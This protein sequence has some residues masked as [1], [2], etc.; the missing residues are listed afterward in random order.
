[1]LSQ[2]FQDWELLIADD[3]SDAPTR[4][5]LQSLLQQPRMRVLWL[6]H[7]GN[8]PAVR[9]QALRAARGEFVAFLDSDDI[10]VPRKL[11]LQI[12]AM[13]AR[14]AH[15]WSY[16]GFAMID[17]DGATLTGEQAKRQP[18]DGQF[19]EQLITGEAM[20]MQ[21]SVV[22]RRDLLQAV[23]GYDEA[24]PVCGDYLLW[25]MLAQR[26]DIALLKT[27]L[28]Q[29]RRHH[30]HYFTDIEALTDMQR[31]CAGLLGTDAV[32]RLEAVLH[33][34]RAEVAAA[35]AIGYAHRKR[36]LAVLRTLYTS[37]PY[38]WRYRPWW[39]GA[40][41]AT[42]HALLPERLIALLRGALVRAGVWRI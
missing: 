4:A 31:I 3:G 10:W 41:S 23:G 34:R 21:S 39:R 17:E 29:V 28:V 20:I 14:A 8:P 27:P 25:I 40:M 9:N 18:A 22:V 38:S 12:A 7:C 16:T 37:G 42:M 26:S 11:E 15:P 1:V 6:E 36:P 30:N 32:P 33:R 19:L 5:Y 35:M 24:L 2:T 13:S